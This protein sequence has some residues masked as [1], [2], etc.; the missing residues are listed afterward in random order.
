MPPPLPAPRPASDVLQDSGWPGEARGALLCAGLLLGVSLLV[1]AGAHGLTLP[2]ALGCIALA[3]LL[4]VVLLPARVSA[5]AGLLTVRGLWVTRTVRTDR[6]AAVVWPADTAGRLALRD[7]SGAGAEVDLRVLLANPA[8]WL[9]IETDARASRARGVLD[10][11]SADLA[12]LALHVEAETARAVL[13]V[14][15]LDPVR[16]RPGRP[17]PPSG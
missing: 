6:L 8:L 5:G 10:H 14:S 16:E 12:R 13:R 11:G 1:D 7:E 3:A 17:V 15:G 4:L 2:G 9:R